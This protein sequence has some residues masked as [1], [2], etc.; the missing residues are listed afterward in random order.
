MELYFTGPPVVGEGTVAVPVSLVGH[1]EQPPELRVLASVQD[2]AGQ[3]TAQ[4]AVDVMIRRDAPVPL[5]VQLPTGTDPATVTVVL[6]GRPQTLHYRI[7]SV[8]L[9]ALQD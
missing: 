9:P 4:A 2:A 5:T 6:A 1:G 3:V 8:P 7:G